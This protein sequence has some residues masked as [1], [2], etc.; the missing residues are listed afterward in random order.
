MLREAQLI[1]AMVKH[2]GMHDPFP[3]FGY[4]VIRVQE[5]S[6][7]ADIQFD[8]KLAVLIRIQYWWSK[9]VNLVIL[10]GS[11]IENRVQLDLGA[12]LIAT[13]SSYTTLVGTKA[14]HWCVLPTGG[15]SVFEALE[16]MNIVE[17]FVEIVPDDLA[18]PTLNVNVYSQHGFRTLNYFGG[19]MSDDSW[20]DLRNS[21]I[22]TIESL[23]ALAG[24][25]SI[26]EVLANKLR[27]AI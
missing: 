25:S 1:E 17:P 22:A 2:L 6:N 19:I 16:R 13:D 7:T 5:N 11:N 20:I 18:S 9:S 24:D 21:T 12:L 23:G 14:A 8:M 15:S 10:R 26:L 27:G 4:Q 3:T